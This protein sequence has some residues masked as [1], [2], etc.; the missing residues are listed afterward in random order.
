[1]LKVVLTTIVTTIIMGIILLFASYMWFT[2]SEFFT[3]YSKSLGSGIVS[4]KIIE[5]AELLSLQSSVYQTIIAFLMGLNALLAALAV[6]YI[7]TSSDEVARSVVET[8]F[9][10]S[11]FRQKTTEQLSTYTASTLDKVLEEHKENI[12]Q[13]LHK[14][15]KEYEQK[16]L[17]LDEKIQSHISHIEASSFD[18]DA[19]VSQFESISESIEIMTK[20]TSE[21]DDLYNRLSDFQYQVNLVAQKMSKLDTHEKKTHLRIEVPNGVE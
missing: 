10:S 21:I 2:N 1:M 5:P 11:D 3:I 7:K 15:G 18:F 9:K 16:K 13:Q 12:D 19:S 6:Y 8:Y 14:I 17:E 20:H 4:S